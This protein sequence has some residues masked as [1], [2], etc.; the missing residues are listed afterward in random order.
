[1]GQPVKPQPKV[2]SQLRSHVPVVVAVEAIVV[3]HPVLAG[4]KLKLGETGG[5]AKQ[6]IDIP[7]AREVIRIESSGS[8]G[9]CLQLLIL[10]VV[11][12]REAELELVPPARPGKIIAVVKSLVAV[13]PGIVGFSP[14]LAERAA[15]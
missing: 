8:L 11:Q 10:V 4:Q 13:L 5:H 9:V 1:M 6:K 14:C 7:V 3:V 2:E 12:P 15:L